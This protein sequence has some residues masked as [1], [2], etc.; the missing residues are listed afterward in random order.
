MWDIGSEKKKTTRRHKG[1][2][3]SVR[4]SFLSHTVVN[5]LFFFNDLGLRTPICFF[6]ISIRGVVEWPLV[7]KHNRLRPSFY[8]AF[9]GFLSW[10][11]KV[12]QLAPM[13]GF[14]REA[15]GVGPRL[16]HEAFT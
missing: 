7:S 11:T 8:P 2:C 9:S 16:F 10:C 1:K 5:W 14:H 6:N 4:R 12:G 15:R 13:L 3:R